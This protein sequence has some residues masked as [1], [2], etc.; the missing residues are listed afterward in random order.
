MRARLIPDT[1][2]VLVLESACRAAAL[3][4]AASDPGP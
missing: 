2:I 3:A 1:R 4:D